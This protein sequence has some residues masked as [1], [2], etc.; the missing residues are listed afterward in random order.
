MK[1]CLRWILLL[2]CAC[3][4]TAF[5]LPPCPAAG[6]YHLC[7]GKESWP[8]GNRYVGEYKSNKKHGQG[9]YTA[10]NG[11]S[12]SGEFKDGTYNGIGTYRFANGSIYSGEF[13]DGKRTGQ[14]VFTR[15]DGSTVVGE[16]LG[17]L[18]Q[19]RV[20]EFARDA[21]LLRSGLYDKGRLVSPYA[22]TLSMFPRLAENPVVQAILGAQAARQAAEAA[23]VAA[24]EAEKLAQQRALAE[25]QQR[26]EAARLTA[27]AAEQRAAEEA[28]LTR[29]RQAE[30]ARQAQA[31]AQAEAEMQRQAE[32]LRQ[33]QAAADLLAAQQAQAEAEVQ[34]ADAQP[35]AHTEDK[36]TEDL[37]AAEQQKAEKPDTER[38]P[39]QV[40]PIPPRQVTPRSSGT[41]GATLPI[42]DCAECPDMV[43]L[44]SG[45]LLMKLDKSAD[46]KTA[47]A[48]EVRSFA[49]GKTEVTQ[50]QWKAIMGDNPSRFV[51]CGPDCPVENVSWKD[52]AQ[53]IRKLNQKT[54]QNYRL[55]S[56]SEWE[57]A[58]RA[59]GSETLFGEGNPALEDHAWYI[60]NSQKTSHQVAGKKANPFGL[61]DL[62]GNVWEW[63][64]DCYHDSYAG[65]PTDGSAWASACPSPQR[66]LRGGSWSDEAGSMRNRGRYAPEVRNLI[67]GFRLARSPS[68]P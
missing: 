20:M 56:E 4:G 63:V 48:V 12:Y 66:V 45:S 41:S 7:A 10:A 65:L 36:K 28:R 17:D 5:A 9:V 61:H 55:P 8:N 33:A 6:Y 18:A 67:T 57:Y 16:W 52:V 53:F 64:E 30:E 31:R 60:A 58:A 1:R 23:R 21:T 42:K 15:A 68:P 32:L 26:A 39:T 35:A 27:E 62:Y 46:P 24:A 50:R 34:A 25:A 38:G 49:I 29:E 37:Q 43:L 40:K 11:D 59:G 19:G 2:L 54:G 47:V 13:K 22:L 3:Y 14:G 44:P 51:A